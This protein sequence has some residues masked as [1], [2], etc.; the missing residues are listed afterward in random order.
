[1]RGTK[2]VKRSEMLENIASEL[3]RQ[4]LGFPS[5]DKCQ[6]MAE[7]ILTRMEKEGMC[8]S[9]NLNAELSDDFKVIVYQWEPEND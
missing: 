7:Y 1:M 6:L 5:F 2:E 4:E 9:Y 3:V 8:P